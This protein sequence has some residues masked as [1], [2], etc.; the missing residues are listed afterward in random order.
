MAFHVTTEL[1]APWRL[2]SCQQWWYKVKDILKSKREIKLFWRYRIWNDK[3]NCKLDQGS[4]IVK[5]KMIKHLHFSSGYGGIM[6]TQF[7]AH[8][9]QSKMWTK[10]VQRGFLTWDIRRHRTV[11]ADRKKW[12]RWVKQLPRYFLGEFLGSNIGKKDVRRI[13]SLLE[14]KRLNLGVQRVQAV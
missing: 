9:K 8:L 3:V 14:F 11:I 1:F 7:S 6:K 12:M 4:P 10:Y 2:N 13:W 5:K